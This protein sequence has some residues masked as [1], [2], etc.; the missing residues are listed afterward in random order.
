MSQHSVGAGSIRCPVCAS[1]TTRVLANL[2][3]ELDG[4]E[5]KAVRCRKCRLLFCFP[6]P[7]L[8][9]DNLQNIY[10]EDYTDSLREAEVDPL[11]LDILRTATQRQM[12]I[13]EHYV[14]PGLALNVGAMSGASKALEDRGW[15]LRVVEVSEHAAQSARARW[16]L[17]VTCSRIEDFPTPTT[18]FDFVKLGHVIE[19]LADPR[20]AL[21]SIARITKPGGVVLIDTDNADGLRTLVEGAI[22]RWVGERRAVQLVHALTGKNLQRLYGRLIPPVHVNIFSECSLKLLLESTGFEVLEVR[23]PG[24]GDPT[25]FPLVSP[26]RLSLAEQILIKVDQLGALMNRGELI[27]VLA[28]RT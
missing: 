16:G 27:S 22:R 4:N 5:Y 24:W 26:R 1:T 12:E 3:S 25:W 28:R 13:V 15:T 17:D 19:H 14:K 18:L 23:K 8:D 7:W 10:G 11:S 20:I 21:Q 2:I 9:L 6:I